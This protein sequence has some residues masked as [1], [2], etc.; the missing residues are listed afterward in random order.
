[1]LSIVVLLNLDL[2]VFKSEN[3]CFVVIDIAIVRCRENC[4]HRGELGW[5]VPLMQFVPVHL[6][7]MSTY[8]T[9][10]V[11]KFKEVVSCLIAEKEGT[12]TFR[13]L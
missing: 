2:I 10:E 3:S 11:V 13:V 1:M 9:E 5:T 8:N 4:D 7:L 6:N 12:T